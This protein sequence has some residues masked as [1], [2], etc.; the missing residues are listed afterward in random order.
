MQRNT[1]HSVCFSLNTAWKKVEKF[2]ALTPRISAGEH[3]ASENYINSGRGTSY[4][5]N[6]KLIPTECCDFQNINGF[7]KNKTVCGGHI[8]KNMLNRMVWVQLITLFK[9]VHVPL[10]GIPFFRVSSA[11]LLRV[12]SILSSMSLMK[13]LNNAGPS[14]DPWG[15]LLVMISIRTLSHWPLPW[16]VT[17]Q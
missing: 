17:I 2:W 8:Q 5:L 9:P 4:L 6:A 11:T 13:I 10:H 7:W 3:K 16:N 14:T 15:I 1:V 12:H